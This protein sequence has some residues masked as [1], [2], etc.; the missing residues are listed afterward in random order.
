[1]W[2]LWVAFG[3]CL[4]RQAYSTAT[5]F[6]LRH[7]EERYHFVLHFH[8]VVVEELFYLARLLRVHLPDRLLQELNALQQILVLLVLCL[9]VRVFRVRGWGL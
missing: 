1:M 3:A 2:R 8:K 6:V 7:I 9:C 4:A 5:S